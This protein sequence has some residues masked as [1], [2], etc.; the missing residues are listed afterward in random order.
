M[1]RSIK[2]TALVSIAGTGVFMARCA[3]PQVVETRVV[4]DGVVVSGR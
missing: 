2:T 4:G 1:L 3:A